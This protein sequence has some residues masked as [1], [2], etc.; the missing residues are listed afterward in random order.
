MNRNE[1]FSLLILREKG[2]KAPATAMTLKEIASEDI[3][4]AKSVNTLYKIFKKLVISGYVSC[5]L[6]DGRAA[7]YYITGAGLAKIGEFES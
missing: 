4:A 1:L 3:S 6:P 5:G 2:A 7:T